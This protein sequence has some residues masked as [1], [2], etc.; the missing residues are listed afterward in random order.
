MW[1]HTRPRARMRAYG[2]GGRGSAAAARRPA[3]A[4]C[5]PPGA[6]GRAAREG[7][8]PGSPGA[9]TA[10]ATRGRRSWPV[11]RIPRAR[12]EQPGGPALAVPVEQVDPARLVG[13]ARDRVGGLPVAQH[14]E[15]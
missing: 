15:V 3:W 7:V 6:A 4:A 5:P 14:V 1:T 10:P 11:L 9:A 13:R 8:R 2:R 12:R